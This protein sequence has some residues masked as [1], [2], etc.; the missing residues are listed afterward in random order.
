MRPRLSAR[1]AA[2]IAPKRLRPAA[3]S[4]PK[5]P[6][7]GEQHTQAPPHP[8]PPPLRCPRPA[9]WRAGPRRTRP[10]RR[11]GPGGWPR[12]WR[13]RR[14]RPQGPRPAGTCAHTPRPARRGRE[15]RRWRG[16]E[17][18]QRVRVVCVHAAGAR[19]GWLAVGC[20]ERASRW[21]QPHAL[22][23]V[24]WAACGASG[25]RCRL[26]GAGCAHQRWLAPGTPSP[27]TYC[28]RG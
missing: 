10:C 16:W 25:R 19:A 3:I 7:P 27:P 13:W 9:P 4:A 15:G 18:G 12:G 8:N 26:C 24:A 11:G 6:R 21:V 5:R 17:V 2:S 20:A 14:A 1:P 22:S 23:C 28:E